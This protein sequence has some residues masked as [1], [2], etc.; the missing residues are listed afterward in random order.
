MVGRR[1]GGKDYA[2]PPDELVDDWRRALRD[3]LGGQGK[4]QQQD[5][6]QWPWPLEEDIWDRWLELA[7]DPEKCISKWARDGVPLGVEVSIDSCG[8]SP[9]IDDQRDDYEATTVE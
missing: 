3:L 8:I 2:G 5:L 4:S 1:F 6:G 7:E 9:E